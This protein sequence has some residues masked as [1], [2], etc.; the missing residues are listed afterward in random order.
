MMKA[1]LQNQ[2]QGNSESGG[3][4]PIIEAYEGGETA[5][6]KQEK[7]EFLDAGCA[8]DKNKQEKNK[9]E[10]SF[11]SNSASG[12]EKANPKKKQEVDEDSD[13]ER[14]KWKTVN[15]SLEGQVRERRDK[16]AME[17]LIARNLRKR[18]GGAKGNGLQIAINPDAT[19]M[20]KRGDALASACQEQDL[21]QKVYRYEKVQ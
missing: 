5:R 12:S 15:L 6:Q 7:A 17:E 9:E 19:K 20:K 11:G 10:N 13:E 8:Y 18:A 21:Y 3:L 1:F 16:K 2:R 4:K 14:I